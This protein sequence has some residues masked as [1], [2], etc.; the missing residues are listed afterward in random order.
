MDI[1]SRGNSARSSSLRLLP[2]IAIDGSREN[3]DE[4]RLPFRRSISHLTSSSANP[5]PIPNAK[6]DV[7]PPLP[8]PRLIEDPDIALHFGN[9]NWREGQKSLPS[10]NPGSSLLGGFVGP[11]RSDETRKAESIIDSPQDVGMMRRGGMRHTDEGY[12]SLSGSSL[13]S[14]TSVKIFYAPH[15][16]FRW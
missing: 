12:A 8:P 4:G 13:S 1:P 9:N 16:F 15:I 11:R 5:M 10:I 6:D 7:P 14:F 2:S 3:Q